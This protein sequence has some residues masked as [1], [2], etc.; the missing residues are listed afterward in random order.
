MGGLSRVVDH[1]H[2]AGIVPS[3]RIR[4]YMLQILEMRNNLEKILEY[5]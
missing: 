2:K 1:C 3:R 4:C 5:N